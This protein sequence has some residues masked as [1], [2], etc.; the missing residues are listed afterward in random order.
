MNNNMKIEILPNLY[1][2]EDGTFDKE[3]A[4]NLCGKIAGVC[5][6]KEGFNHLENEELEKTNKRINMTLNNGHHSVYD[7]IFISFNLQNI[8]KMLA[9]VLNNEKQYT[10]SE[11]SARYT[12]VVR[13]EDSIIT[14][15]EENLYNKWIDIYSDL[16]KKR[17]GSV[18][19]DNKILKLAQENARYL[20]TVFMPTQMIYTTSLRQI[21]NIASFMKDYYNNNFDYDYY[22]DMF[23][24]KLCNYMKEFIDELDRLNVLEERLMRN[25]KRRK[26]SL[27]SNRLIE[28]DEYFGN[29]YQTNYF[30]SL[31]SLAQ[32]QRHRTINYQME[33][34]HTDFY[35]TPEIIKENKELSNEWLCDMEKVGCVTPQGLI[36]KIFETGTYDNFI[37]K[38]KERLCSHA[39]LE[40]MRQTSNTLKKYEENLTNNHYLENDINKHMLGA[41]CTFPDYECSSDC[42]FSEGKTLVRKI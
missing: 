7:H 38:C 39:Q 10:T 18:F 4:L 32:A 36:V 26:L 8:P 16:I 20:I 25:D 35:Y 14:E 29:T 17:Y 27:F 42:K 2:K 33:F 12:P 34:L 3:K 11:K 19:N 30:G 22:F 23:N 9:M 24:F 13:G 31:A 40:I 1:L 21:N 28:K 37:L 41:R 5:Y 15:K 6:D